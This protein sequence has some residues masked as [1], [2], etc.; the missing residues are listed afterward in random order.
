MTSPETLI[1]EPT[2]AP[3]ALA[4][5]ELR[6]L[7]V[8]YAVSRVAAAAAL[9]ALAPV[10][11][12]T[13]LA[14]RISLGKGGVL[15]RQERVGYL[16]STFTIIKFRSM[17]PDRR[18]IDLRASTD[19]DRRLTHKTDEDPRHTRVGRL[20]RKTSIDELPQLWNVVR[21][22]MTLIGPRPE[23]ASIVERYD[24]WHH[25]R[26]LV[27]PGITGLWQ[28]SEYRE[29]LLHENLDVDIDYVKQISMRTDLRILRD[30]FTLIARPTGS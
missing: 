27:K 23:L 6:Y 9:I 16:G 28:V 12:L 22:E 24:L 26:H 17:L 8:K 20:L 2:V 5:P 3:Y 25:P 7:R 11:A 19:D 4:A 18:T 21:G 10:F 15:Y 30:T 13:A 14:V 1:V 29:Q